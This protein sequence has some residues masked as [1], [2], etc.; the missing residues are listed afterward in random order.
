MQIKA[1]RYIPLNFIAYVPLTKEEHDWE[2]M[3]NNHTTQYYYTKEQ[4]LEEEG[5]S[6][7]CLEVLIVL[8]EDL[9]AN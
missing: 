3:T 1:F 6:S 7:P 8:F 4:L 9:S 2:V 5:E